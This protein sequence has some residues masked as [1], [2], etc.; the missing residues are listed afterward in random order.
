MTLSP[1]RVCSCLMRRRQRQKYLLMG[2]FHQVN[3]LSLLLILML[4]KKK[5][6]KRKQAKGGKNT[7]RLCKASPSAAGSGGS[8]QRVVQVGPG[9]GAPPPTALPP[10]CPSFASFGCRLVLVLTTLVFW[11]R[12]Y[13]LTSFRGTS[14]SLSWLGLGTWCV[15]VTP[16]HTFLQ[17]LPVFHQQNLKRVTMAAPSHRAV[18]QFCVLLPAAV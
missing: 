9:H 14:D 5:K 18:S 15:R 6:E 3:L 8:L 1:A 16:C 11:H 2:D 13:E 7:H 10:S 4:K 12:L 17:V